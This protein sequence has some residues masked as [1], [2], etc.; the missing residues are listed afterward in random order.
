MTEDDD[1]IDAEAEAFYRDV[2]GPAAEAAGRESDMRNAVEIVEIEWSC[3]L[4]LQLM[5]KS[6]KKA[7]K[8]GAK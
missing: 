6:A 4:A 7:K 5:K 2:Y 1:K 3:A 8:G